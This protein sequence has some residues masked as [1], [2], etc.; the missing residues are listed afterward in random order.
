M[1]E[2]QTDISPSRNV[3]LRAALSKI[4]VV[5][6]VVTASFVSA[7]TPQVL[8]CAYVCLARSPHGRTARR[9]AFHGRRRGAPLAVVPLSDQARDP[10]AGSSPS[11]S[12]WLLWQRS[13]LATNADDTQP[14][15]RQPG[16]G[17]MRC[18]VK[19]RF[20]RAEQETTTEVP[21]NAAHAPACTHE[22]DRG[23]LQARQLLQQRSGRHAGTAMRDRWR[24]Y[25]SSAP[26]N[27]VDNR[28]VRTIGSSSGQ[29]PP[30]ARLRPSSSRPALSIE[31]AAAKHNRGD[32]TTE[33]VLL[34]S[35]RNGSAS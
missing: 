21:V 18:R 9:A 35:T 34:R 15:T 33:M 31:S 5:T 10:A 16:G 22:G 32:K 19:A 13:R 25:L 2:K 14:D 11:P 6:R 7:F 26:R 27:A 3:F 23:G 17:P 29:E 30:A 12:P 1:R 28:H 4:G 24:R 8:I 20:S